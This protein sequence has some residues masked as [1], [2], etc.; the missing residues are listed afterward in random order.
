MEDGGTL[1]DCPEVE[2]RAHGIFSPSVLVQALIDGEA[3]FRKVRNSYLLGDMI[4]ELCE[5]LAVIHL[6]NSVFS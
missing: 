6:F 5:S 2:K 1:S 4:V 3:V